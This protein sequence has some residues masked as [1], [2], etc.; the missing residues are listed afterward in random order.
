MD[1]ELRAGYIIR[2]DNLKKYFGQ[3]HR[4]NRMFLKM[5]SNPVNPVNPVRNMKPIEIW[6]ELIHSDIA[7]KGLV[8]GLRDIYK[9]PRPRIAEIVLESY[10]PNNCRHCI[11]PPDYHRFNSTLSEKKWAAILEKLYT[12]IGLRKYV[13][14][15]RSL[16]EQGISI[17]SNFKTRF[18]DSEVGIICDGRTI[19]P[20][21]AQVIKLVPDWVD[22][23]VDGLERDHDLQRNDVG[24]F[25]KT[26][27]VLRQLKDSGVI[28][29]VNILTCL[30]TLNMSSVLDMIELLNN[31]GLKNFFITPV[32][33]VEGYRPNPG[34]APEMKNFIHFVDAMISRSKDYYD[35]WIELDI[36]EIQYVGAIKKLRP[37][38]FAGFVPVDQHLESIKKNGNNEIHIAYYPS[39]LT[40]LRELVINSDGAVTVP[41]AM[42]MGKI[43]KECIFG[44][45]SNPAKLPEILS[46]FVNRQAFS[47][48]ANDIL[49]EKNLLM[50]ELG[51]KLL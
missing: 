32:T 19:E 38:L 35:T 48:F 46:T 2:Q 20:L 10:C 16:N 27:S 1:Q 5:E 33:V 22:I 36:Y 24:A 21:V 12:A 18:P 45:V 23:S 31:M 9:Y 37:G 49:Q 30:T 51:K 14:S 7:E 17:I 41:K 43:Q 13:F 42:A 3:D 26:I 11:Y 25:Q 47:F 8:A 40:G 29:K 34:L 44:N 15:G 28:R 39:S 6:E 4:I 50:S